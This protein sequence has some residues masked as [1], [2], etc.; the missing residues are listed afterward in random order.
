MKFLILGL[1]LIASSLS[2]AADFKCLVL[3]PI[4]ESGMPFYVWYELETDIN[5]DTKI[6]QIVVESL[7]ENGFYG[8]FP[9]AGPFSGKFI[10]KQSLNFKFLADPSDSP[11]D[12]VVFKSTYNKSAENYVGTLTAKNKKLRMKCMQL[13]GI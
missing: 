12:A 9:V 3:E 10:A 4:D 13:K 6:S 2:N 7:A 1:T 8:K 5:D 11:K